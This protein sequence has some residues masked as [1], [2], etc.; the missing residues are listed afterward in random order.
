M[1]STLQLAP[2]PS[3]VAPRLNAASKI[4]LAVVLLASMGSSLAAFNSGSTGADGV[5][6][7]AVSTE[8]VLPPS[9]ILQYTSINIPTGVT[10]TFKRN[11]L[12][13][14]VQLLVSGDVTVAGSIDIR[15]LDAKPTGTSGDGNQADDGIPV[16][17]A[18]VDSMVGA[19]ARTISRTVRS[20]L[21]AEPAWA[22]AAGAVDTSVAQAAMAVCTTTIWGAAAHTPRLVAQR[23]VADTN[24]RPWMLRWSLSVPSHMVRACWCR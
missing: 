8:I 5:L 3:I 10:V 24:A 2:R 18:P 15:G 7:P 22:P 16:R 14:P 20:P 23:S 21:G 13:T 11:V 12:N 4:T 19:A 1:N 6:N 17:A 9:G